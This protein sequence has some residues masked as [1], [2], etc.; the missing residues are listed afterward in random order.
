MNANRILIVG[1]GAVGTVLGAHFAEGGA[2]VDL[3]VKPGREDAFR[4]GVRLWRVRRGRRPIA[5]DLVVRQVL[6][7]LEDAPGARWDAVVLCISSDAL[8]EA[9]TGR[10]VEATAPATLV[11]VGQS[12]GDAAHLA[13][14]SDTAERVAQLPPALFAWTGPLAAEAPS[15][16]TTYWLAPG[17]IQEVGGESQRAGAIVAVLRAGGLRARFVADAG[18]RGEIR[19]AGTMPFV[20][21]LELA[22]WSF[23]ALRSSPLLGTAAAAAR[24]A[25]TILT[26]QDGAKRPRRG[27]PSR[28]AA[29]LALRLIPRLAPF[30]AET[31]ARRQF[32]KV[33]PQMRLMLTEWIGLAEE[34][35][36]EARALRELRQALP[37]ASRDG[38]SP[39]AD[40]QAAMPSHSP[41][42]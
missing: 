7:R 32:S 37:P 39:G 6:T 29:G 24:E 40:P 13:G 34:L 9:W 8:R 19:A 10:L 33:G 30:D 5:R 3:L 25:V 18:R 23:A 36:V 15:S 17:A 42:R 22:G 1:G 11:C 27:G 20:A 21:A 2:E 28:P 12:P 35:R 14:L 38:A 41:R 16:G 31:Y 26:V 4:N